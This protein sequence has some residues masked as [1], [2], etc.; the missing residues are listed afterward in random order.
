M[1]NDVGSLFYNEQIFIVALHAVMFTRIFFKQGGVAFQLFQLLVGLLDLLEVIIPAFFQLAQFAA[2]FEM[3]GN[4][5]AVIKK[6]QPYSEY[7]P[8]KEVLVFQ[9]ARYVKEAF[10]EA[11]FLLQVGAYRIQGNLYPV[12]V[13]TLFSKFNLS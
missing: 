6:Q 8:G 4:H 3:G 7:H 1:L 10:Q 5:I 13:T 11:G 2:M 12:P 9:P